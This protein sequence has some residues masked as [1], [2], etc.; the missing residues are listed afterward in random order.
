MRLLPA[1]ALLGAFAVQPAFAGKQCNTP[2]DQAAFEVQALRT[3]LRG[4][5]IRCSDDA[6]W[7]TFVGKFGPDL[8]ANDKSV[9]A[10]FKKRYGGRS[11]SEGDKFITELANAISTAENVMG[12]DTC[13]H[14]GV[15]FT[16]AMA[17][18]TGADLAAYAA[19]KDVIPPSVDACPGEQ[20]PRRPAG[21]R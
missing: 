14:D 13:A 19:A 10:W 15:M 2:S 20:P 11:T 9:T 17:L 3:H 18:R 16:E 12:T 7:A 1:L 4:L 6:R 21:K 5:A 8:Q